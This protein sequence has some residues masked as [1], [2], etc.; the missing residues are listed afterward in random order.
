MDELVF[1]TGF[2]WGTATSSHQVEGGNFNSDWWNWEQTPGHIRDGSS[3]RMACD[4][5]HRYRSDWALAHDLGQ[6]AHRLSIEWSRIQPQEGTWDDDAIDHYRDVLASL[7]DAGLEPMVTLH[8]FT[9]P[10]WFVAKGGWENP[11]AVRLFATYVTRVVSALS[12]FCSLWVTINEPMIYF[13]EGYLTNRWPPGSG[14][15]RR[16]LKAVRT[17]I[18]AHGRAYSFIHAMQPHARVGIAHNMRLFDPLR[19]RSRLDRLA[20]GA[21]SRTF[22]WALL[23]SLIDGR[24]RAPLGRGELVPEAAN[25]L[26]FIGL[27]Y[28]TRDMVAFTVRH[29]TAFIA[30]NEPRHG[31]ELDQFGW[32]VY[33]E[34]M[35]R[36]LGELATLGKPLYV[37]EN[38]IAEAGDTLRPAYIVRTARAMWQAIRQGVPLRG[39]FHWSLLDNF[40]WAEGYS[41]PFG[42]VA[43]DPA[44]QQRTVKQSGRVYQR[45]CQAN[46]VPADLAE[47]YTPAADA[48]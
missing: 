4:H 9:N 30:R 45:I 2:L 42:L 46:G 3:S 47:Q 10:R 37:T 20:A 11:A 21:E 16:G 1:P 27:N 31:A 22:N 38:G 24:L 8:H 43:V 32:E 6:N 48:T 12:E 40:E 23:W 14:G 36:L 26:D 25:S 15:V 17:M 33:P 28:Y 29:A 41:V 13:Y 18:R 35:L 19:P 5:F 7:C 34:G 39:Y 44:T